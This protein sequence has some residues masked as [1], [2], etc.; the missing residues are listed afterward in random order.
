MP[1][2]MSERRTLFSTKY[3]AFERS[4]KKRKA[5]EKTKSSDASGSSTSCKDEIINTE[6]VDKP[7]LENLEYQQTE[8][9]LEKA[10]EEIFKDD[11]NKT[12]IRA[13]GRSSVNASGKRI[14]RLPKRYILKLSI[15][16]HKFASH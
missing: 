1:D 12:E 4:W 13:T 7:N 3:P 15:N 11:E 2:W 5:E 10:L 8:D 14:R 6:M 16:I 9:R